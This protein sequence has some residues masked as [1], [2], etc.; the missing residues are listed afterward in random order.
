[1]GSERPW[2]YFGCHGQ[3]GHFLWHGNG[4]QERTYR[5]PLSRFDGSL[6]FPSSVGERV[7]ALTRLGAQ[8]YSALAFWDYSVDSRGGSNSIIFAPSLTIS[9]AQMVEGAKVHLS[10]YA[11][12]WPSIDVSRAEYPTPSHPEGER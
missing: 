3:A 2:L 5:H 9:A 12:R 11:K 1:M 10:L 4:R 7:A 6:C 8:G